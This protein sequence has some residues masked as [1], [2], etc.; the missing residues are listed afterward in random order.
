M[1][2]DDSKEAYEEVLEDLKNIKAKFDLLKRTGKSQNYIKGEAK[3][4]QKEIKFIKAEIRQLRAENKET[5]RKINIIE[6]E[7]E[8]ESKSES[9]E[10]ETDT[11]L[12]MDGLFSCDL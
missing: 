9:G 2:N 6:D 7:L 5:A 1:I 8:N 10:T 12:S 3:V 11:Y 4:F